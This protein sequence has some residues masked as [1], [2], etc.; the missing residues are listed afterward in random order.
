MSDRQKIYL[1]TSVISYL[2]ARPSPDPEKAERQAYTLRWMNE[3]A[4][5]YDL[6][7][8]ELVYR[9]AEQGDPEAAA[10]RIEEIRQYKVVSADENEVDALSLELRNRHQI[11]ESAIADSTHIAIS[12]VAGFDV[13]LTWNCRHMANLV[14]LPKTVQV[15]TLCGYRCPQI[16]TPRD[17]FTQWEEG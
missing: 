2:V 12:A 10:R 6:Y 17:F 7:V 9:E 11:F 5:Q 15:I 16:L 14:A 4:S 3:F 8:S 13:L 1:E